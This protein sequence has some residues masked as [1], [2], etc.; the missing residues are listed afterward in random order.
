MSNTC[1]KLATDLP[2]PLKKLHPNV[3]TPAPTMSS[4]ASV[5]PWLYTKACDLSDLQVHVAQDHEAERRGIGGCLPIGGLDHMDE[6]VSLEFGPLFRILARDL[7]ACLDRARPSVVKPH[8]PFVRGEGVLGVEAPTRTKVAI[9][10]R[11]LLFVGKFGKRW[12][13]VS[14]SWYLFAHLCT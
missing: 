12:R 4:S 6:Q 1:H 9:V 13:L 5:T 3:G 2:L 10:K 7:H 8:D 14:T 11:R